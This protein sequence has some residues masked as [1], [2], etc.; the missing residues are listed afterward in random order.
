MEKTDYLYKFNLKHKGETYANQIME[1]ANRNKRLQE[2][3][4]IEELPDHL[5]KVMLDQ[6]ESKTYR[7][8]I[9][10]VNTITNEIMISK[11]ILSAMNL[12]L[13][14]YVMFWF[15]RPLSI[16]YIGKDDEVDGYKLDIDKSYRRG[17]KSKSAVDFFTDKLPFTNNLEKFEVA[18]IPNNK[19]LH[20]IQFASLEMLR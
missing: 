1:M 2:K 3:Y 18:L 5:K 16:A 19:G 6:T 4:N 11:V 12:K 8:P 20:L 7:K 15:N 9:I 10:S 17:F 13:N 14:D